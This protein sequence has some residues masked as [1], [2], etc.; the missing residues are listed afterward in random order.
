M[1]DGETGRA[2]GNASGQ[3]AYSTPA[4]GDGETSSVLCIFQID[5]RAKS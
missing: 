3:E 4:R 1:A 2:G 5:I